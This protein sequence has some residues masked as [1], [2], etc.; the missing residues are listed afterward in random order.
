M[1]ESGDICLGRD[2]VAIGGLG[3]HILNSGTLSSTRNS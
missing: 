3:Q 2:I 1:L